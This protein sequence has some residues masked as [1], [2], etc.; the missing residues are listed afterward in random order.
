VV[1]DYFDKFEDP[2]N[3]LQIK[4]HNDVLGK[5]AYRFWFLMKEHVPIACIETCR[6][7]WTLDGKS[8]DLMDL[9]QRDRRIWNLINTTIGELLP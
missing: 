6:T 4:L 9:Y 7:I 8:F 3:R 5:P 2:K 1:A